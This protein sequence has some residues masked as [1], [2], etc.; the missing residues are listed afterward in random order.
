MAGRDRRAQADRS[1]GVHGMR[2][3][4]GTVPGLFE[5]AGI[6]DQ[7]DQPDAG[8]QRVHLAAVQDAGTV[9]V[10]LGEGNEP[11]FQASSLPS[12]SNAHG[13]SSPSFSA[14]QWVVS[15][16]SRAMVFGRPARTVMS[17]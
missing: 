14:A 1:A 5:P 8:W 2:A 13:M 3:T 15:G 10:S 17:P 16:T 7:V 4:Q 6:P 11:H 9:P 12:H